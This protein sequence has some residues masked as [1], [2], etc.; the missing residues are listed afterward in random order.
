LFRIG[1]RE[2]LIRTINLLI[3]FG[4]RM[5]CLRIG[6][7]QSLHIFRRRVIKQIVII[8]VAY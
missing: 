2:I 7:S 5:N 6:R 1:S 8:I 4:T 3:L